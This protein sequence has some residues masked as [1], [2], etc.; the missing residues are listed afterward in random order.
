MWGTPEDV[1]KNE[2][3][4]TGFY[5]KKLCGQLNPLRFPAGQC[6]GRLPQ[7]D[8]GKPHINEILYKHLAR[9]LNRARMI[10]GKHAGIK[11]M[12]QLDKVISIDQSPIGRTPRSNP[13][14][15]TPLPPWEPAPGPMSTIWSAASI[16]SSSW[17]RLPDRRGVGL[18]VIVQG[19][20]DIV[21]RGSAENPAGDPDWL[22]LGGGMLY[23][24]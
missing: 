7:F 16:V 13:A 3:S 6:R 10:P 23:F 19:Y 18:P 4:Y 9:D 11:G 15:A 24:G 12:E 5:V 21:R 1:A 8:I 17:G 14:C 2:D 22:R 20:R